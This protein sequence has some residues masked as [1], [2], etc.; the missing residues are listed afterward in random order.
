MTGKRVVVV[1]AS[2]GLGRTIGV[3]LGQKAAQVALLARRKDRLATAAEEAGNGALAIACDVTDPASVQAAI[4][5]AATG[6]G[7]IDAVVYATGVGPLVKLTDLDAGTL[8]WAFSTNVTGAHLVTQA[9][10]PHLKASNGT[11][12]YLS[13]VIGSHTDPWP[14]LAA[15]SVTKAALERLIQ[16]WHIEHPDV[17]FTRLTVGDT[18]GGEGDSHTEF[19]SGWNRELMGELYPTWIARNYYS[20]TLFD[21]AELQR[22]VELLVSTGASANIPVVVV[23]PRQ[24]QLV[25]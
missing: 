13:S 15:Y 6:L 22:I 2:S 3:H 25:K 7:G 5:E 18:S 21:V 23:H 9:A 4:N 12:I 14:G 8:E 17:G 10:L 20:G 24:P 19:N 16:A 11:V 1:G